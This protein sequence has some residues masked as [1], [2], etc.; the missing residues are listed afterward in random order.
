MCYKISPVQLVTIWSGFISFLI[1]AVSAIMWNDS[2]LFYGI[3][4]TLQI[5][6]PVAIAIGVFTSLIVYTIGWSGHSSTDDSQLHVNWQRGLFRLYAVWALVSSLVVIV[7]GMLAWWDLD[8]YLVPII[9]IAGTPWII[10][11]IVRWVIRPIVL[12][13]KRGFSE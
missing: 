3:G 6:L 5:T 8:E 2:G 11:F 7:I 1:F 9:V 4:Q 13:I 10:H 12:W